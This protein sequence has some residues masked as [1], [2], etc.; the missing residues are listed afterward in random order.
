MPSP[1]TPDD[2]AL[3]AGVWQGHPEAVRR[4]RTLLRS[5]LARALAGR[6]DVNDADL[7]DFSQEAVVRVVQ[8]IDQYRGESRFSTW[9]IAVAVRVA[10]THVR[11]RRWRQDRAPGGIPDADAQ[12]LSFREGERDPSTDGQHRELL[13]VLRHSIDADL[14]ERQRWAVLRFLSGAPQAVLAGELGVTAGAFHKLMHDARRRLR[15][16]LERAGFN[17]DTALAILE[18]AGNRPSREVSAEAP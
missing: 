8:R 12:P 13:D 2:A 7:D 9:A 4:L 14:T 11:T 1:A 16:A 18:A 5:A 17:A 15:G 3:A 10:M 6:R